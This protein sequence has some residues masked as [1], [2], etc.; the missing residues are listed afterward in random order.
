MSGLWLERS[1]A[2][3]QSGQFRRWRRRHSGWERCLHGGTQIVSF[4]DLLYRYPAGAFSLI[5]ECYSCSDS[6]CLG[7]VS[8]A[9]YKVALHKSHPEQVIAPEARCL[10]TSGL[11]DRPARKNFLYRLLDPKRQ[12]RDKAIQQDSK[13]GAGDEDC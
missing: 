3:R 11:F 13:Q 4:R 12:P 8:L 5:L 2:G 10:Q 7:S 9:P 1:A 6:I